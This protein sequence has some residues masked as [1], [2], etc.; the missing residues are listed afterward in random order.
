MKSS[1]LSQLDRV[2]LIVEFIRHLLPF[3]K[4]VTSPFIKYYIVTS[5]ESL[6]MRKLRWGK[7]A[8]VS[9]VYDI[10]E[11][12]FSSESPLKIEIKKGGEQ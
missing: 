11:N 5:K 4:T 9:V 2:Y 1:F 3:S 6:D 10:C 7:T 8:G 12:A